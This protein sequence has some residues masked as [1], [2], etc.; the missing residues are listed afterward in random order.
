MPELS[1]EQAAELAAACNRTLLHAAAAMTAA[2]EKLQQATTAY[3][4]ADT[5]NKRAFDQAMRLAR[6]AP[7]A[8]TNKESQS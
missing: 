8:T 1:F 7:Q 2:Q 4:K 3:E 5:E 6:N